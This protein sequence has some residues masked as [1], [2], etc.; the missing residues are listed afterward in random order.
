MANDDAHR[1]RDEAAGHGNKE[2]APAQRVHSANGTDPAEI[3]DK[4]RQ[5]QEKR[6]GQGEVPAA[7]RVREAE[8]ADP[9][10][11]RDRAREVEGKHRRTQDEVAPEERVKKTAEV[12]PRSA[13][14][15]QAELKRPSG[16]TD[17]PED[18]ESGDRASAT[19]LPGLGGKMPP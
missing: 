3:R 4:A 5:A 7:E 16:S 10:E 19:G 2:V 11:V 18:G 12:A 17:E 8:Q 1:G 6:L 13:E 15:G 14:Q 9:A